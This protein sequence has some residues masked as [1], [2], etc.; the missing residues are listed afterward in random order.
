MDSK[1]ATDAGSHL[2]ECQVI[3]LRKD[4]DV[5]EIGEGGEHK[6]ASSGRGNRFEENP[7]MPA[8]ATELQVALYSARVQ[9]PPGILKALAA[10]PLISVQHHPTSRA[11]LLESVEACG[12]LAQQVRVNKLA[13]YGLA[14]QVIGTVGCLPGVVLPLRHEKP[15]IEF[16]VLTFD[17]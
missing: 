8:S 1:R 14:L 9:L 5:L 7:Q 3:F 2:A 12:D 16:E 4:L 15:S 10:I 11:I 13:G 6:A 17:H